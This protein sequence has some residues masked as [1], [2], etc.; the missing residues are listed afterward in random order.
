[1]SLIEYTS[2]TMIS[3]S[4]SLS[5]ETWMFIFLHIWMLQK[6]ITCQENMSY[7]GTASKTLQMY[8]SLN[9]GLV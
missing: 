8:F 6:L 9:Y 3:I 5:L 4:L 7:N 2:I 1:M